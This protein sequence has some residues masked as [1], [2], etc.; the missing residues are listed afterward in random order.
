MFQEQIQEANELLALSNLIIEKGFDGVPKDQKILKSKIYG[1]QDTTHELVAEVFGRNSTQH[2]EVLS[3]QLD[4]FVY[5]AS[6]LAESSGDVQ[7]YQGLRDYMTRAIAVLKKFENVAVTKGL[8]PQ[9]ITVISTPPT[10]PPP[11]PPP[12]VPENTSETPYDILYMKVQERSGDAGMWGM[13]AILIILGAI[14][15]FGDW[16][17]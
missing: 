16:F 2:K 17:E 13:L 1:W 8:I 6:K 4:D 10:S 3:L 14:T 11:Q 12:P 9:P 15:L 7:E 5:R